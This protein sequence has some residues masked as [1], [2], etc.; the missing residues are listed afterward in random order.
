[1]SLRLRAQDD[2]S[3]DETDEVGSYFADELKRRGLSVD[4]SPR[5]PGSQADRKK[6]ADDMLKRAAGKKPAPSFAPDASK[7][8][9]PE[10]Q[11]S[12]SR[13]L[14]SEGLEGLPARGAELLKLGSSF[15]LAF[16]PLVGATVAAVIATYFIFGSDFVH[17]GSSRGP[18]AYVEPE[19]L[20]NEPT[21]DRMVPLQGPRTVGDYNNY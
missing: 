19:F 10:D 3:A 18:P 15:F 1:V 8:R 21:V 6:A 14:N 9:N 13:A 20:L 12:R 4:E 5:D 2:D 17:T 11:L 7:P 16:A